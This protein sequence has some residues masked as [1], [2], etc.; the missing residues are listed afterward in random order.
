MNR[1]CPCHECMDKG[2]S[3]EAEAF[4]SWDEHPRVNRNSSRGRGRSEVRL[5]LWGR[6]SG[7]LLQVG[8]NRACPCHE[9]MDRGLSCEAEAFFSWDEHPRVDRNSSR[10][11]GRSEVRLLLWGRWSGRLQVGVNRA[12]PC[13]DECMDRGLSCEAE[14]FF[15]WDEH[16][17]VD[18]N[19]SR[20]RGRSEVRLLLWG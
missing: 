14:A 8:V 4:F 6:W 7:R 20:G 19:S 3:C 10:G 5:L 16:P 18:R 13:H 17:R 15:S 9:C 2:L 11:R 1:A 12:C